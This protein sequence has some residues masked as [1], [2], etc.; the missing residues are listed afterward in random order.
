MNTT[1]EQAVSSPSAKLPDSILSIDSIHVARG[2]IDV[3]R[4]V[5]LDVKEGQLV[6]ILGANG[7][8][9]TTLL[10]ALSGL[11]PAHAGSVRFNGQALLGKKPHHIARAGLVH[12]PEGRG[13][14]GE[15]TVWENLKLGMAY[16]GWRG[17]TEELE[18]VYNWFPFLRTRGSA[19]A[20]MLSGGEQ[21]ML[22]IAR[23]LLCRPK[24]L[25]IDELSLG[26]APKIT[27]ELMSFLKTISRTGPTVLIVEQNAHLA[28]EFAD[29]IYVL[30]QGRVAVSGSATLLMQDSSVL[31]AYLGQ[32]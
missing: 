16:H 14:L 23:S 7:A 32:A 15:Q 13:I 10:R 27:R 26:L 20:G 9:K 8:G 31:D 18:R 29:H 1:I 19:M 30:S 3:L 25:M 6:A 21:Q 12:V 17:R 5:T 28:L 22:A 24:M 2:E 4:D 11:L